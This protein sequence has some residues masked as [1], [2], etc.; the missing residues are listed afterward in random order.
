MSK[1]KHLKMLGIG[2]ASLLGDADFVR[3]LITDIVYRVGM[4]PLAEPVIHDV[5][6]DL[7]KLG[8]EP[9]EDEGGVTGQLV[10]HVTLSTSH[11][12]MFI[13]LHTWPVRAEFNLDLYSCRYFE[14]EEVEGFVQ[15]ICRCSKFQSKDV[16]FA[17]D[18][19]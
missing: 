2:D 11:A 16:S 13:A 4:Q 18:W 14:R 7:E 10:G 15:D 3:R 9:F 8:L 12:F 17:A 19:E 5:P 6:L 1:A